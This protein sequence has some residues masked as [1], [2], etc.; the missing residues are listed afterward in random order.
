M[1]LAVKAG[2]V[3]TL[4]LF[5]LVD[6]GRSEESHSAANPCGTLF[7]LQSGCPGDVETWCAQRVWGPCPGTNTCFEP[8]TTCG[9]S[10]PPYVWESEVICGEGE[11]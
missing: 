6:S 5:A 8:A 1:R 11:T 4:G 7:C 9:G 2:L 10:E 3:C